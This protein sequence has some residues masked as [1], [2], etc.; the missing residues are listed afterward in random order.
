MKRWLLFGNRANEPQQG[1]KQSLVRFNQTDCVFYF[2]LASFR[3][4]QS[5]SG[6]KCDSFGTSTKKVKT[7]SLWGGLDTA[8]SKLWFWTKPA[9]A[10][11][12]RCAR[13]L[14]M[15]TNNT[16]LTSKDS[17]AKKPLCSIILARYLAKMI[18]YDSRGTSQKKTNS[19][20]T[21][22]KNT[23]KV[24]RLINGFGPEQT[25]YR[26]TKNPK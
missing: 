13:L 26:C 22:C 17:R 3:S 21:T 18:S 16:V 7:T 24:A 4:A 5:N 9:S 12:Q 25:D 1:G 15:T 2:T 10:A 20:F 19:P 14:C 8:T 6:H 23:K 11:L